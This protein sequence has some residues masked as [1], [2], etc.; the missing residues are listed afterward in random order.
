MSAVMIAYA[1]EIVG[2]PFDGVQSMAWHDDGEHPP[3]SLILLGTCPG[4]RSCNS[5]GATTCARTRGRRHPAYWTPDEKEH[6][7]SVTAYELA[8]HSTLPSSAHRAHPKGI[9]SG[10]A[11]YAI[12]GLDHLGEQ[13]HAVADTPPAKVPVAHGGY[14]NP[15]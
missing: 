9:Q 3:P 2:G 14:P 4:D 11:I 15:H 8:E 7:V 1:M 6:P 10:R 12:G 13:V 5:Q